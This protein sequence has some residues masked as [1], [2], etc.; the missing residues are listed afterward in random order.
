MVKRNKGLEIMQKLIRWLWWAAFL[1]SI[2]LTLASFPGYFLKFQDLDPSSGFTIVQQAAT[3]SGMLASIG[4]AILCLVLAWLVF[5]RR[6]NE[7][8]AIFLSFYLLAYSV[9]IVGPLEYFLAYW[10]PQS[11]ELVLML[12]SILFSPAACF[13]LLVFPNGRF[14]PRWTRWLVVLSFF[15]TLSLL[16]ILTMDEWV[17]MTT[18]R[19]R[20]GF[21]VIGILTMI[22]LGVQLYRYRRIY[23]LVERQQTKWVLIG[24]SATILISGILAIP[25]YYLLNLPPGTPLPWWEA[26]GSAGWWLTMMILPVSLAI[27]ILR[28]RLFDIDVIIRRTLVYSALTATLALIFF[29]MVTLLQLLFVTV[30]GHQSAASVVITTLVIAALFTPLRRR[31]QNDIDRRFYRKKYDAD[32]VVAAFGASLRQEVDLDDLQNQIVAVVEET[33]QPERVSLWLVKQK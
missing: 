8:I 25:Y 19:A 16:L 31:I 6:P 28:Y 33:L 7:S 9:F 11:I 15:L 2:A 18:T 23:T 30:I 1:L 21:A 10:S 29:G 17:R 13:L 5:R 22:A 24:L 27:A 20:I 3:W 4:S 26:L 32:K 12:Q 14:T